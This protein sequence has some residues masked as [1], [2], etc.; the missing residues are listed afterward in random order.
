MKVL[1]FILPLACYF[2][3]EQLWGYAW[4]AVAGI[5]LSVTSAGVGVANGEKLN[6]RSL[7]ADAGLVLLFFIG[8]MVSERVSPSASPVVT[9]TLITALIFALSPSKGSSLAGDIIDSVRPMTSANPFAMKLI[10]GSFF[11]MGIWS[12][13]ATI[14]YLAAWLNEDTP[15]A[16]WIDSNL[17]I[18]ILLAILA[19]EVVASHIIRKRY[20]DTEW[21]PLM[22]ES[23]ET[24]GGAPRPL[25]HDGSHW[26]HAVVHLHVINSRGELLL[27]LRPVSKK[28][29]PGKWDTAV[30]GH[31]TFGERLE[32]A[33]RRET[34]EEIGLANF[35]AQFKGHYIWECEAESEFVFVFA[36]KSDGPFEPKNV[37]E[38]DKLKFWSAS[39]LK[40]AMGTGILTPNIEQELRDWLLGTL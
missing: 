38:V 21:V 16:R 27:Q 23:G 10:R 13:L 31:I 36:T 6:W 26:L 15:A 12:L 32:D 1:R 29:Q 9:S 28:I 18:T 19:T 22:T 17:L 4:G 11:R 33:L 24:V 8:D 20:R 5:V 35:E 2:V 39:E 34:L 3:V 14:I 25:V 7:A 30:G 40:A 37:G